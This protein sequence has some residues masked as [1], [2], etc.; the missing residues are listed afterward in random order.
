[1]VFKKNINLYIFLALLVLIM[2][3][4]YN[5]Q[6]KYLTYRNYK[7]ELSI[8]VPVYNV[9]KY[10]T[11]CLKSLT[12]QTFKNIE[13]ICINDG[14][15]DNSLEKLKKFS[16]QDS[17]IIVID[18]PNKGVSASRN[19]GLLISKGEFIAFVDSDDFL[20]LNAYEKCM[21][22]FKKNNSD[23]VVY[24]YQ[25]YPYQK[26]HLKLENHF[27]VNDSFSAIQNYNI[28]NALW[29]KVFRKSVIIKNNITFK[30]DMIYGED[31]LF[32]LMTFTKAERI[33]TITGVSY[34]YRRY[35]KG[36]TEENLSNEKKLINDIKRS[37]YLI[38]YFIE[39]KYF[40]YYDYL[41]NFTLKETFYR[42][43]N[44]NDYQKKKIYSETI[45]N[46]CKNKLLN[47]VNNV[48]NTSRII[49]KQLKCLTEDD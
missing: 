27:Y 28:N 21:E 47:K 29:N 13:I 24:E 10:I 22:S 1:M 7:I 2:E 16:K 39:N 43:V 36:N 18:Q 8:I 3:Y 14:S 38:D 25:L 15:T 5:F 23:I 34:H 41:L 37:N 11:A 12:K 30:E 4:F 20:D 48:V 26:R 44:L 31:D 49:L 46:L 9:E 19:K 6:N 33:A 35:R 17:R 42:I 32:R 45:L 40:D